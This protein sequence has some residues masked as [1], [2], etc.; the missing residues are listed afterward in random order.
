MKRLKLRKWVKVSLGVLIIIG[1]VSFAN[2]FTNNA[3][4][5]CVNAGNDVNFCESGLR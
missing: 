2:S 4:D 5:K 1:V 3:V